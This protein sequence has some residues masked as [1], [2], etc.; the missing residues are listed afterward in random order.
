MSLSQN[1]FRNVEMKA[2]PQFDTNL[3]KLEVN[4][5]IEL[6][7]K[8][9][10]KIPQ[11]KVVCEQE[12]DEE[13]EKEVETKSIIFPTTSSKQKNLK[14]TFKANRGGIVTLL[15]KI[16][17]LKINKTLSNN[18]LKAFEQ[19][20]ELRYQTKFSIVDVI[21][22]NEIR[23]L[24]EI[25]KSSEATIYKARY[26]GEIVVIKTYE[27]GYGTEESEKLLCIKNKYIVDY[28]RSFYREIDNQRCFC[29]ML[30]YSEHG[31]L[32]NVKQLIGQSIL[33]K[34]MEDV[35]KALK[36]LHQVKNVIHRD[37]KPQNILT[38]NSEEICDV[39]A[40]ITYFFT[41][42]V[43][44]NKDNYEYF[45]SK[46]F[47]APEVIKG[48]K[49]TNKCDIYS[50]GITML[51]LFLRIG[52]ENC[53][54]D[55]IQPNGTYIKTTAHL[56]SDI[57]KLIIKCCKVDPLK[58]PNINECLN[59]IQEI[60]IGVKY[61]I[62]KFDLLKSIKDVVESIK[63]LNITN[64]FIKAK[65]MLKFKIDIKEAFTLMNN[66][67]SLIDNKGDNDYALAQYYLET[68]DFDSMNNVYELMMSAARKSQPD[69]I[70]YLIN[71][72]IDI[73]DNKI[74]IYDKENN[75]IYGIVNEIYDLGILHNKQKFHF[76][77]PT[78]KT[79]NNTI[80]T[81]III[82]IFRY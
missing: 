6:L 13:K 50:L 24:E 56:K 19:R 78:Q 76:Q 45:D 47:T 79:I 61:S 30:E 43:I 49:Y 48:E 31:S 44:N 54:S 73:A 26:N 64:D 46:Y 42:D 52:F 14:I 37:I 3:G 12:M 80:S 51:S 70:L 15:F 68:N 71:I 72:L 5:S 27:P 7:F 62:P 18:D 74:T 1:M 32:E 59:A 77:C 2:F 41:C 25:G 81:T 10:C 58:R 65:I 33:Y 36:Y 9:S 66:S 63:K 39:N 40:K 60:Q 35:C 67:H 4:Q 69:A 28:K 16:E 34:I 22:E 29:S 38:L 55:V 8:I 21:P 57:R 75:R 20:I 23:I 17:T 11:V 53:I 82:D